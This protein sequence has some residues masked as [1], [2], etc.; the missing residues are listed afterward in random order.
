MRRTAALAALFALALPAAAEAQDQDQ[1]QP[2]WGWD[3]QPPQ[4]DSPPVDVNVG[5]SAPG[6]SVDISSFRDPLAAQGQWMTVAGYGQVW[7][8]G[9][10]APGW[11]PYYY[12][13]WEWTNEGWLWVSDEPW[14]WAT[15]HYGRWAY[16][17]GYGWLWVPGYQWAPAWVT[18]R[19]GPDY[20]G[21]APLAPGFS[22]YVSAYP[23]ALTWWTFMPCGSFVGMPVYRHA[24]PPREAQ[25]FWGQTRPAPPRVAVY[26]H[27]APAWGG[28]ARGFVETRIGRPVV[29]VRV[30]PVGSPTAAGAPGRGGQV[31]IY[32]PE[33]RPSAPR[34]PAPAPDRRG[35]NGGGA[36]APGQPSQ[37]QPPSRQPG[38]QPPGWRQGGPGRA[39]A[40]P[41]A[42]PRY[43]PRGG[44]ER[45]GP[46]AHR[47]QQAPQ[48]PGQGRPG[49]GNQAPPGR[50]DGNREHGR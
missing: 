46:P 22:V 3:S 24:F 34:G 11:R 50:G 37:A 6:A 5:V 20:V 27:A 43:E 10:V 26:G 49:Q 35:W 14:G 33:G 36:R 8:P 7:R 44:G 48:N 39:P 25:R 1:D 47:A 29:P 40:P 12:G 4:E 31:P 16:D 23:V 41:I 2:T 45:S 42:A 15:Y 38:S 13:R 30:Q 9:G 21:W 17:P 28:P 19:Y 18:W 32:R